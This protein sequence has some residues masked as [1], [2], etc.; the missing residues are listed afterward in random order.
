LVHNRC[1][2]VR[3]IFVL[4]SPRSGTTMIGNYIGS[5]RSVLNAG[6]YRALYL[7]HGSLPI[8]LSG[9]RKL[10]GLIP[11]EWEPFR[12]EYM[13]EVQKHAAE[14]ITRVAEREGYIA[15]CDSFPRN[16]LIGGVLAEIFPEALFVLTVRH[17]TGVIQ[18]L[19]RLETIRVLPGSEDQVD[20]V[21]PTT[22][23]AGTLWS[24]HYQASFNLPDDRT[25]VFGYDRFCA[26]PEPTLQRFK[27]QLDAAGFPIDELD[28]G[29]FAQSH[30]NAPG[31][32]RRTTGRK[33]GSS[34]QW[35]PIPSYDAS[36]WTLQMELDA[37][38]VV[39]ATDQLMQSIFGADYSEPVGYPGSNALIAKAPTSLAPNAPA[40]AAGSPDAAPARHRPAPVPGP[41]PKRQRALNEPL[42]EG[43]RARVR[44][45]KGQ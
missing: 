1:V 4:G 24:R 40:G 25:V 9:A 5:A 39:S 17:Y 30:A 7:A 44:P 13:G 11:P 36:R 12:R 14:F 41:T 6:E 21:D 23:A 35:A 45:A 29:T 38:P 33:N 34:V 16:V 2:G 10:A 31:T 15:F 19:L 8:Q 20:W 37:R 27:L 43:K 3:P 32:E 22:V 18:S 42:G 26:D 28:D